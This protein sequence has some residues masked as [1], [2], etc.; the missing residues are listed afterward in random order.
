MTSSRLTLKKSQSILYGG[1]L[2]P[3]YAS[4]WQAI[5]LLPKKSLNYVDSWIQS[6]I[7]QP[8]IEP[9]EATIIHF[10][11]LT[12]NHWATDIAICTALVTCASLPLQIILCRLNARKEKTELELVEFRRELERGLQTQAIRNKIDEKEARKYFI[13]EVREEKKKIHRSNK[14]HPLR[15]L[16]LYM[17]Y[18]GIWT[19]YM[20]ALRNISIGF[21]HHLAA[22]TYQQMSTES[23]GWIPCLTSPDP[24]MII[25][26]AAG[27]ISLTNTEVM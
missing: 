15:Y 19:T 16:G 27:L 17:C 3:R 14:S 20:F 23:L 8:G 6:P 9:V 2:Q 10:H 12:G 7:I 18:F 25:P 13:G 26:V 4:A 1:Q 5:G 21:P 11:S 22:E 24:Y